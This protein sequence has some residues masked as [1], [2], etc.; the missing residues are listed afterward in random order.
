MGRI[1]YYQNFN[2]GNFDDEWKEDAE[3]QEDYDKKTRCGLD[4]PLAMRSVDLS[5]RCD[6][7][8]VMLLAYDIRPNDFIDFLRL[9]YPQVKDDKAVEKLKKIRAKYHS[10]GE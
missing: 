2:E 10:E 8:Y 7:L 1:P 9:M 6:L 4:D 3:E 5:T